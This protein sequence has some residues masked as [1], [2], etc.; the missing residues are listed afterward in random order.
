MT[1][2]PRS[3]GPEALDDAAREVLARRVA[4]LRAPDEVVEEALEWV[5]EFPVGDD[6]YAIPL[7][8]LRSAVPL[9]RVTPVPLASPHVIGILRFSGQLLAALSMASLLGIKGWNQDPVVLL[10]V[11]AGR[12]RLAALDCEEIPRPVGLPVSAI[13]EARA[14][15]ANAG[16]AGSRAA[17]IDVVHDRG[18]VRLLDLE[19][20]LGRSAEPSR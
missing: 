11:D 1:F 15:A 12:G 16:G 7:A 13:G 6:R 10:V 17:A 3:R 5:A 2:K 8:A 18:L 9:R 14:R 20:L 4:R 19:R